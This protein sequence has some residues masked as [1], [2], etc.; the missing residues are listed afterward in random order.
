LNID[1]F[2]KSTTSCQKRDEHEVVLVRSGQCIV[3][4]TT[5]AQSMRRNN[6]TCCSFTS[7]G[8]RK[9]AAQDDFQ[10]PDMNSPSASGH[11]TKCA[12]RV[13]ASC[14]G[15]WDEWRNC[16]RDHCHAL[17]SPRGRHWKR[18]QFQKCQQQKPVVL[19]TPS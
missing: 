14:S 5:V 12:Q 7:A 1:N 9:L 19:N 8:W 3:S 15:T 17:G 6:V 13:P 18:K 10:L 16:S 2:F 11:R 4:W